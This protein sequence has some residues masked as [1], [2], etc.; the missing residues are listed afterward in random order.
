ML[1]EFMVGEKDKSKKQSADKV[2]R[3]SERKFPIGQRLK[4]THVKSYFVIQARDTNKM[5]QLCEKLKQ[6]SSN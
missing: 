4:S 1:Q 6:M 3:T 5:Y 2:A